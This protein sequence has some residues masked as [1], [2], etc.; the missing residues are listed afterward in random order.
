MPGRE[1]S[2]S[3]GKDPFPVFLQAGD[4]CA[5]VARWVAALGGAARA[6]LEKCLYVARSRTTVVLVRT[7]DCP[8][9]DE[10]R[11]RGWQEPREPVR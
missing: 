7:R 3:E 9:A 4:R 2:A 6:G 11:R 1:V 8:L 10:L 5:E